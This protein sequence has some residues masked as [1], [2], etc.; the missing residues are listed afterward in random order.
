MAYAE[1]PADIGQGFS[2]RLALQSFFTLKL[3]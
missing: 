1:C 3:P 2:I